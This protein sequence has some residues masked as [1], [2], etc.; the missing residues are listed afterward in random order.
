M[1]HLILKSCTK[2]GACLAE[3]PTGSILEGRDQF[4]IDAD[5]CSDH[6]ACVSVCPVDAIVTRENAGQVPALEE[7]EE[8]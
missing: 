7:E 8:N 1:A 3:C 6:A 4:Y 5:S 2:C